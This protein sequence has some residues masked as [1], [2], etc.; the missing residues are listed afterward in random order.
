MYKEMKIKIWGT[1]SDCTNC[2]Y[3][4]LLWKKSPFLFHLLLVFHILCTILVYKM[5]SKVSEWQSVA[6]GLHT[7]AFIFV[8]AKVFICCNHTNTL[9]I[10]IF[11]EELRDIDF[12][13]LLYVVMKICWTILNL[14]LIVL[15]KKK[16]EFVQEG[17]LAALL[18][19]HKKWF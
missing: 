6:I 8:L 1:L 11:C 10:N 2:M 19:L 16:F 14:E 5:L 13:C 3:C 17:N 15:Y 7:H 18:W 12:S 9:L 4:S